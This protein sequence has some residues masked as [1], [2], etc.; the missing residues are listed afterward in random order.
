VRIAA[1]VREILLKIEAWQREA[2]VRYVFLFHN[3]SRPAGG[4]EPASLQL[5]PVQLERFHQAEVVEWPS[6]SLPQFTMNPEALLSS[7]LRQYFFVTVFRACAQSQA[8]EHAARLAAMQSAER[9]LD[10]RLETVTGTYRRGRQSAITAEL[11]DVV[12]GFEVIAGQDA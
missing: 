3:R 4:F 2:A 5:L 12:A 7:L 8:S 9:N 10:D 1:T 11:L 6:R